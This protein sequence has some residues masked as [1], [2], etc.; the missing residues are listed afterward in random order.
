MC[1][2]KC[3][4]CNDSGYLFA[5]MEGGV[6]PQCSCPVRSE[7][8]GYLVETPGPGQPQQQAELPFDAEPVAEQAH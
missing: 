7:E 3:P 4:L 2:M 5:F 6:P 8:E 1:A